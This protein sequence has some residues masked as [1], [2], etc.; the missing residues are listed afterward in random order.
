MAS[1]LCLRLILGFKKSAWGR[2]EDRIRHEKSFIGWTKFSD[3]G[4]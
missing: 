1:Q 4:N 3:S 2:S